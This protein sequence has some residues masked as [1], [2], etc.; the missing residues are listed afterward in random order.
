MKKKEVITLDKVIND[1]IYHD[2]L[3]AYMQLLADDDNIIPFH[4]LDRDDFMNTLDLSGE[5]VDHYLRSFCEMDLVR[6][7]QNGDCELA[8]LPAPTVEAVPVEILQKLIE[9]KNRGILNIYLYLRQHYKGGTF[10]IVYSVLAKYSGVGASGIKKY[11]AKL[12]E[13]GLIKYE[14]TSVSWVEES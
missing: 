6:Q 4:R 9:T 13:L 14:G 7:Y 1:V 2:L 5:A 11:M 10:F 12:Q 3:Y 8:Q